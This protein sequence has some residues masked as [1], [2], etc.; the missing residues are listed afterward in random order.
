MFKTIGV[1]GAMREEIAPFLE[2]FPTHTTE[3]V[4]G[5]T[6]YTIPYQNSQI[7]LAY[8]KIGKVH[9]SLTASTMI[10]RYGIEALIFSGVAG[11]LAPHLN[12]NDLLLAT[13][14]CQAD[15]DL[16]AFGHPLGFIPESAVFI[17]S[18]PTLNDLA[19]QTAKDLGIPLQEGVIATCDQFV[20]DSG[21]KQEWAQN[22][23]AS[24]VEMEGAA[25]AFVCHAFHVPFCV[26]RSVSDRANGEA[27]GDFDQFLHQS[28]QTSAQFVFKMLGR[29]AN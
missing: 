2:M 26:L 16:S 12:I 25:V 1:M 18:D 9:A 7:I 20:S 4:G 15:V 23:G 29:L 24:V 22:F 10:L 13:K 19:R 21:R 3:Q 11:G 5:N 6:F 14:L 27:P 28:A 8:S 17:P